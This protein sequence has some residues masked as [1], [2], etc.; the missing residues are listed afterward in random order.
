MEITL[1]FRAPE[2]TGI[3]NP[4]SAF[5][6]PARGRRG[7]EPA[8]GAGEGLAGR[9]A[10]VRRRR[11]SVR[12]MRGPR[13]HGGR[14]DGPALIGA[15]PGSSG[16]RSALLTLLPRL[17]AGKRPASLSEFMCGG[18]AVS[19]LPKGGSRGAKV[20]DEFNAKVRDKHIDA[21]RV[22]CAYQASSCDIRVCVHSNA[23]SSSGSSILL[24]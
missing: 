9:R 23:A 19:P 21:Y 18:R 22:A 2:A 14:V 8:R 11:G 16:G 24:T 20:L 10:G 17:V 6:S 12:E 3:I 13:Q 7:E 15:G 5:S 1:T 4:G